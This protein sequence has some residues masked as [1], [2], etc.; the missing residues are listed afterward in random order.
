M[1][2]ALVFAFAN[3][4][5]LLTRLP[6]F[7]RTFWLLY[8]LVRIDELTKPG[9]PR[10]DYFEIAVGSSCLEDKHFI[11]LTRNQQVPV[12]DAVAL[13]YGSLAMRIETN[14]RHSKSTALWDRSMKPTPRIV[15][16][17]ADLLSASIHLGGR[18][19]GLANIIR[20]SHIYRCLLVFM[21]CSVVGALFIAAATLNAFA[22]QSTVARVL[23]VSTS[24]RGACAGR[25]IQ[26]EITKTYVHTLPLPTKR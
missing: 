19:P 6:V 26:T 4:D 15:A 1:S 20:G 22:V 7:G 8:Q 2:G 24:D 18:K 13:S 3:A 17:T 10:T 21:A 9:A 16:E 23:C 5:R 25:L 12:A 14:A 11:N